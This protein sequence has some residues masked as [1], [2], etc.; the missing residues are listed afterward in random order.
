MGVY[1]ARFSK[2]ERARQNG[3]KLAPSVPVSFPSCP[4]PPRGE[5]KEGSVKGG[6]NSV[7]QGKTGAMMGQLGP[8]VRGVKMA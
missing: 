4:P 8:C 3:G 1:F 6:G 2:T 5:G 7:T